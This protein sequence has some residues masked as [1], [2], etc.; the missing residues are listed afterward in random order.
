MSESHREC[1][2]DLLLVYKYFSHNIR[3][4]T[5]TIVAMMEA[6][7]DGFD[8]DTGEM[9]EL[10]A[11]SGFLL[12][13]FDRGMSATFRYIV[14][15]EIEKRDDEIEIGKLTEHLL[16]KTCVLS[17]TPETDLELDIDEKFKVKNNAYL[18]K[19]IFLIILYEAVKT[20]SGKLEITGVFP[21]LTIKC[22][23]GFTGLP[24]I[25]Q[26]FS[27]MFAKV[28]ILL[29]YDSNSISMRF[30]YENLDCRR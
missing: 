19:S 7:K 2:T 25:I 18:L 29:K 10:V 15:G 12:D 23:N 24:E 26:I 22:S 20:S 4:S 28:G 1:N 13:L 11:Q 27:E 5:S 9:M 3:T 8:D 30:D 21:L 14:A 17:E 16:E 6:V